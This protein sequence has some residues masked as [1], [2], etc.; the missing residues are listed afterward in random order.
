MT[1]TY[2]GTLVADLSF[3]EAPRWYANTLWF[4][5]FFL[6]K[7]YRA[8]P[9]GSVQVIADVPNQPSGLG[10]LPQGDL[11]V[12]SMLDRKV[13]RVSGNGIST[14]AD[15]SGLVSSPCNDM[16][17]DAYG[18]AY[19]GNFG[20]DRHRGETQK[21]TNLIRVD[22]D[23]TS[24]VAADGLL[25][26]NGG[27]L[28]DDGRFMYLAESFGNQVLIFAVSADGQLHDRKVLYHAAGFFPD[29]L[30]LDARQCVWAADPISKH[31]VHLSPKGEVLRT[32]PLPD[33]RLPIACAVGGHEN[34][35][36]FVA[37]NTGLGPSMAQKRDGRIEMFSIA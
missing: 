17:V 31:L 12:V 26:P 25:F 27:V 5:D 19:V 23:G 21:A 13:L 37:S 4:S 20:F 2:E 14:H 9:N 10:W 8:E 32:V 22:V 3:P 29:G 24:S 7:V 33:G 36:L 34:N 15:L 6:K 16:T 30:C 35:T 28:S 18:V 11:L 1:I